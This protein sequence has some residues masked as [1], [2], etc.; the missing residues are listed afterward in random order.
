MRFDKRSEAE[1]AATDETLEGEGER[2][3]EAA[4]E[5]ARDRTA[6]QL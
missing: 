5:R 1:E 2:G 4:G 3:V 6:E